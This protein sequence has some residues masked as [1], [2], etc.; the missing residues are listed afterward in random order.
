LEVFG[1]TFFLLK[2]P[3]KDRVI[4]RVLSHLAVGGPLAAHDR[5]E[6]S[7][8][9][10]YFVVARNGF[11]R[12]SILPRLA[13]K[14]SLPGKNAEDIFLLRITG[15]ITCSVAKNET[16]L[17]GKGSRLDLGILHG[18]VGRPDK[19]LTMPGDNKEDAPII[20]VWHHDR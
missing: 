12:R 1:L 20:G 7:L 14:R 17:L 8:G 18:C 19:D 10:E 5:D 9:D 11:G 15:Q 4:D 13:D 3:Q 6:S 16:N 2:S